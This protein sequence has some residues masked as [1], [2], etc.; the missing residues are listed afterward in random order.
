MKEQFLSV[1]WEWR[2]VIVLIVA[3]IV[4]ALAEWN[5]FKAISYGIMLQAKSKAKDAVLKS[6]KE[7][8]EWVV[9]QLYQFLPKTLVAFISEDLMRTIVHYLYIKAKDYLDDGQLNNSIS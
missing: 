5:K 1:V 7:Q 4:F 6:G 9:K 3:V 8:E 2:F